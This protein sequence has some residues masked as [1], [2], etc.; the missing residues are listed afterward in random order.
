M[1]DTICLETRAVTSGGYVYDV[2]V[3]KGKMG[4]VLRIKDTPGNWYMETLDEYTCPHIAIDFGQ[5]WHCENIQP[6]LKEARRA[7]YRNV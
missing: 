2:E 7:I 3:S 4:W 6:I 5:D 1:Q